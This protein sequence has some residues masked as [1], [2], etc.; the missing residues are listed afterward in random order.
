[1]ERIIDETDKPVTES[2]IDVEIF[3]IDL[4]HTEAKEFLDRSLSPILKEGG[5]L[6]N[7]FQVKPHF[8]APDQGTNLTVICHVK[9]VSLLQKIIESLNID[10]S[11][12][13]PRSELITL[14]HADAEQVSNILQDIIGASTKNTSRKNSS[15]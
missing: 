2:D 15:C 12:E 4:I 8:Q 7:R 11:Q 13:E 10:H 9:D 3:N 6:A 1:M 14:Y 5:L